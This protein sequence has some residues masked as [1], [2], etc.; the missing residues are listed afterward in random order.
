MNDPV[1]PAAFGPY[2]VIRP[3]GRGGMGH[4]YE[5]VGPDG[6]HVAVKVFMLDHGQV[7]LLRRRFDAE[8]KIL[9]RLGRVRDSGAGAEPDGH[10]YIV[11]DLVLNAAG[12]PETLEDVRRAGVAD[13]ARLRAWFD[14][15]ASALGNL[16][17]RGIVHRDVKLENILVDADG[18]A[19]LTDFG[20]SRVLDSDLRRDLDLSTTCVTG[21]TT[22]TRPVLGSYWYLSPALRAGEAASPAS[23]WYALGVAFFRLLTGMWYEP[24][25]KALDLLAPFPA[26]WRDAIPTLLSGRRPAPVLPP[27]GGTRRRPVRR[28]IP[29]RRSPSCS[30]SPSPPACRRTSSGARTSPRCR[31]R[32][33]ASRRTRRET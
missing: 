3:L 24:G 26:F 25:S 23:D 11:M 4:V 5:A 9:R 13:G 2:R 20:I 17:A 8:A 29:P 1:Q 6:V 30:A 18:H 28:T 10:P 12:E 7:D 19:V 32:A 33:S 15:L 22:G 21:E 16:H 31:T 27:R 14:E